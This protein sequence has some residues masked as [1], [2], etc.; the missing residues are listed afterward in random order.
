MIAAG[1]MRLE[2]ERYL[3]LV[4]FMHQSE[5]SSESRSKDPN[6]ITE[7]P[8]SD[9][10]TIDFRRTRL[11]LIFACFAVLVYT[12]LIMIAVIFRD[13][14]APGLWFTAL[15]CIA[16]LLVASPALAVGNTVH[17]NRDIR[18]IL[19]ENCF[20]CHGPDDA[21]RQADL[22]LDIRGDALKAL[23][24]GDI[25]ASEV[26]QRITATDPDNRMPPEGSHKRLDPEQKDLLIRWIAEGA[27]YQRHW[28]FIPP[29]RPALP[30]VSDKNWPGEG[31]DHFILSRLEQEGLGPS[32]EADH[33]TLIR[34]VTFSLTGLPP[35]PENVAAFENDPSADA[36]EKVVDHLL[37][38][39]RYGEHMALGW[40]EAARYADTDGYQND[41][42]RDMFVWRD[43]VIEAINRNKPFDEFIVEQLAGDMLPGATLRQQIASGFNRNHRINSE[44]GS[45]PDEWLTENV[46]DRVDTFGTLF[47]GLTMSCARCHDHKY[48][49]ISQK[50]YYRLFAHFHNVPEWGVGPNNGNSPPFIEV[51]ESWPNLS[52]EEDTYIEPAPIEFVRNEGSVV[53]PAPGGTNTAMVM[54]EMSI[55]RPTYVLRRGLY[56]DPDTSEILQAGAPDALLAENTRPPGNRLELARWLTHPEHP[57]F[58][59]VTVNRSW[60]HFFGTGIV[61]SP[62]NFGLQGE[63]P[64]HPELLDWLATELIR[65]DW[66][67]KAFHKMIVMSAAYRQSSKVSE[68]LQDLDPKNRLLARGPRQRLSAEQLRDQA[69]FAS[70][71]LVEKIGGPSVKPYMPPGLWESV[72]NATYEQDTGDALYR[73]SMYTYW[74]RTTPPPMMTGFNAANR[75][76]CTVRA[77]RANSP[78]HALTLMNNKTFVESARFLA[79]R[80]LNSSDTLEKQITSGFRRVVARA[81]SHRDMD[82]LCN[83]FWQFQETFEEHPE[84]ADTLLQIGEASY[85]PKYDK[86]Y[87]A[88][89]TMVA[90]AILNLDEAIMRN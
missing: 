70:G 20:K 56:D 66:D 62:D 50:E 39:P 25:D 19:A 4:I 2:I 65:R 87:L 47:L 1:R 38:S 12:G 42:L 26:V 15:L 64:S 40:L 37:A 10:S 89:M 57:L 18:P 41:R 83:V 88:G 78:L 43:W 76:V 72:S 51:P 31:L 71:L 49:P 44:N 5:A 85:A 13:Y 60:Q 52:P 68:E 90:S 74:R 77:D 54:Q 21:A 27:A 23:A 45:L 6:Q 7:M 9:T 28:A 69:L 30:E 82:D 53:R 8:F 48:D 33:A 46:V 17:Y 81:P 24:P 84:R 86:P 32:P 14:T 73:R 34:R 3:H 36:Y 63:Y 67:V 55:P 59:R 16:A 35:S 61:A 22:R 75:E 11:P 29:S 79:E 58:A 80:M